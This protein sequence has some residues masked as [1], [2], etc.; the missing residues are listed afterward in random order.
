MVRSDDIKKQIQD[1]DKI[2]YGD[3][4]SSSPD[5]EQIQDEDT[6]E[7]LADAIGNKPKP[8]KEF[9]IGDEMNNDEGDL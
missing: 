4:F 7:L 6:E 1:Q 2:N 3:E 5:N 8:G 9:N